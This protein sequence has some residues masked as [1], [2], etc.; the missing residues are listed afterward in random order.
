M[1]LFL[2]TT[3]LC[4]CI[5]GFSQHNFTIKA[6]SSTLSGKKI[7][8]EI[9]NNHNFIP[10]RHDSV[11]FENGQLK[12]DGQLND[13]SSGAVFYLKDKGKFISTSFVI[14][15][16]ENNI[17]LEL[18]NETSKILTLKSDVK[19]NLIFDEVNAIPLRKLKA[20]CTP[21]NGYY[22]PSRALLTVI[23]NEQRIKLGEYPN[24]F[25]SVLYLYRLGRTDLSAEFA[26]SILETLSTF[27]EPM[28]NS[29]LAK[30]L[31]NE[32]TQLINNVKSAKIGNQ[33]SEFKVRTVSNQMFS[34]RELKGQNYLIVF[35]ATWCGPC[36]LQLPMLK[37]MYNKYKNKGLKVIYF[38]NDDDVVRWK[39]H[40]QSN[41][42]DWINVSE[43]LKP[44]VSKIQ[45]SFGVYAVPTCLLVNK[46]GTIVYNSDEMD[47]EL[48]QLESY[49]IKT[50]N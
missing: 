32:K 45:K 37:K 42:L 49:L 8:F 5:S 25:G 43:C 6:N 22:N 41:K 15:S 34:N 26:K 1:K 12:I 40:V 2:T 13:F 14:D 46:A 9:F 20:E 35:S 47:T 7:Y 29:A 31:Y 27:S 33:A 10:L 44:A 17:N 30:K 39:K 36:Q 3:L 50:I 24:D 38:N 21:V 4:F 28:R 11:T 48:D 16:G 18:L 23:L 19:G